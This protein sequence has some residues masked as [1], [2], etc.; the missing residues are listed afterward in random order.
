[1]IPALGATVVASAWWPR[2]EEGE[3]PRPEGFDAGA[4]RRMSRLGRLAAVAVAPLLA[5]D[6]LARAWGED[7][8]ADPA[9]QRDALALV[10]ATGFGEFASSVAF[11]RSVQARG[12]AAA[13]PLAFQVSVHNAAAGQL[14]IALGL[15]GPSI[16]LCGV[17]GLAGHALFQA[18]SWVSR[19]GSPPVL[20]VAADELGPE[21]QAGLAMA[22]AGGEAPPGPCAA[23]LLL[24]SSSSAVG[25]RVGL[26]FT[27]TPPL[28]PGPPVGGAAPPAA[29]LVELAR[30]CV[31][32]R[33]GTFSLGRGFGA[34]VTP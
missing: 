3:P 9:A 5:P 19:P 26:T 28:Q 16:T 4:W 34:V 2:G 27:P 20:L 32:A 31:D 8:P 24:S 13:S 12:V 15:R 7:A 11:L 22:T 17:E 6:A 14:S 23:A 29:D 33:G 1:M 25:P 10:W 18:L 30:A 21:V